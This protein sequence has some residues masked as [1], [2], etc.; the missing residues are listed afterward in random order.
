M[1]GASGVPDSSFAPFQTCSPLQH[2]ERGVTQGVLSTTW[3]GG[4]DD[5]ST[6][7]LTEVLIL[8]PCSCDR[9]SGGVSDSLA[10][11]RPNRATHSPRRV[12]PHSGVLESMPQPSPNPTVRFFAVAAPWL[13]CAEGSS[14]P[15]GAGIRVRGRMSGRL[16]RLAVTP[17][18]FRHPGLLAMDRLAQSEAAVF[19]SRPTNTYPLP[20]TPCCG[21]PTPS[22]PQ[23]SK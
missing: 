13:R 23:R 18:R 5:V 8:V 22:K 12:H 11:L 17:R 3:A 1:A 10:T 20:H 4:V 16:N 2:I 7:S 19:P 21:R 9:R 15:T 14:C 6:F